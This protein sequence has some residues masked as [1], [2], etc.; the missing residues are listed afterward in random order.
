MP[1]T[2]EMFSE[3]LDE[4]WPSQ[5][6]HWN[7]S[8]SGHKVLTPPNVMTPPSSRNM[9]TMISVVLHGM[10]VLLLSIIVVRNPHLIGFNFGTFVRAESEIATLLVTDEQFI[11]DV[12]CCIIL[13]LCVF[14]VG[15]MLAKMCKRCGSSPRSVDIEMTAIRCDGAD[16]LPKGVPVAEVD[17][18]ELRITLEWWETT[19]PKVKSAQALKGVKSS[20][21][22]SVSSSKSNK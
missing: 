8:I 6:P 10:F 3:C 4:D 15:K 14:C 22:S 5:I 12:L 17:G 16:G 9:F 21:P 13:M 1:N 19:D 11:I 2:F 18:R 20:K 7:F